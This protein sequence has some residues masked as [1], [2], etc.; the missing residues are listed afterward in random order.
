M[1]W[2]LARTLFVAFSGF[3]LKPLFPGCKPAKVGGVLFRLGLKPDIGLQEPEV[4]QRPG[5]LCFAGAEL[6]R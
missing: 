4:I 1:G 6:F 3:R 5:A 2:Y